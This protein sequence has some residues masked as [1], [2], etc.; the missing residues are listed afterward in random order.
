MRTLKVW[1]CSTVLCITG[2][3]TA[4][5]QYPQY[6]F[7]GNL[8]LP[9][10]TTEQTLLKSMGDAPW[11]LGAVRVQPWLGLRDVAYIDNVFGSAD[12][13]QSDLTLTFGA[14]LKAYLPVG[15][16][17]VLA[18]HILPEYVWWRDNDQLS[19]WHYRYGAGVFGFFNRMTLEVKGHATEQQG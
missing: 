16:K 19:D 1:A 17:V 13:P 4:R 15:E 10:A 12:D 14:G 6:I 7:P 2:A 11:R 9:T 5:A 8:G 3:A 18:A